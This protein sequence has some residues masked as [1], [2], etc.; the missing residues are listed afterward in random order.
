MI[1]FDFLE[2]G[3][4][5]V[6]QPHFVYD[7]SRKMFLMS[8]HIN[9]PNFIIWLTLPLETLD[10]MGIAIVC[11]PDSDVTNFEFNFFYLIQPQTQYKNLN[12]LRMKRAYKVK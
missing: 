5:L 1:N 12:I 11:F 7:F 9:G 2:K 8:Y 6:S 3:L 4:G 10:N